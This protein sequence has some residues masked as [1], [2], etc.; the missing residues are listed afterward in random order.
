MK[1]ESLEAFPPP[2]L[3]SLDEILGFSEIPEDNFQELKSRYIELYKNSFVKSV[4]DNEEI[5]MELSEEVL[6]EGGTDGLFNEL[7]DY[8]KKE[9]WDKLVDELVRVAPDFKGLKVPSPLRPEDSKIEFDEDLV[10]AGL[11]EKNRDV[12]DEYRKLQ[13]SALEMC[14]KFSKRISREVL[15]ES[16]KMARI[17]LGLRNIVN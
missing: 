15:R 1:T 10:D 17:E 7:E 13:K 9:I 14:L 3:R 6:D 2:Y 8:Y 4:R 12:L 16:V 11:D 5:D